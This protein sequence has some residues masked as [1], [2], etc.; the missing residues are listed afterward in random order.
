MKPRSQLSTGV[1][2]VLLAI[3][4]SAL[5]LAQPT[6]PPPARF[7]VTITQVKPEMLNEWMDIQKNEVNPM[8]K[9]AGIKQRTVS[10]R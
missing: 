1:S 9:K 8:L 7:F 6:P 5:C 2:T 3:A 10:P 4:M